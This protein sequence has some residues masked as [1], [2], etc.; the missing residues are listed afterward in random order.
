MIDTPHFSFVAAGE[1]HGHAVET[2][3]KARCKTPGFLSGTAF[4]ET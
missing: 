3:K 1:D 4:S 2:F